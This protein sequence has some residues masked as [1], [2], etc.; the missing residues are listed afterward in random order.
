VT[1]DESVDGT[2]DDTDDGGEGLA[3][4]KGSLAGIWFADTVHPYSSFSTVLWRN[5]PSA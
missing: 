3:G 4:V 5:A 2:V 1:E